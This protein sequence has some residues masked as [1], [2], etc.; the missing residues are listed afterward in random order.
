MPTRRLPSSPNLNHLKNQAKKLVREHQAGRV[1]AFTRIK[2]SFPPLTDA[3]VHEILAADFTLC[4]AQ[5][6]VSREYGFKTWKDLKEAIAEPSTLNLLLAE[7]PILRFVQDE[8]H[9]LSTADFPV[10]ISGEKGTGKSLAAQAIH[11]DSK[12]GSAPF[13]HVNCDSALLVDSEIFGHEEGAF[14]GARARRHGKVEAGA[15]GTLFLDEVGNLPVSV[16]AK[17]LGLLENGT[18]ER[19][20]GDEIIE[21]SVR[22]IASTTRD[23]QE[24]VAGGAFR[25]DLSL[26]LGRLHLKLL[27]LRK[28][29]QDIP[30]LVTHFAEQMAVHMG[31]GVPQLSAGAEEAL[32]NYEWPGN[33]RELQSIVQRAIANC[34]GSLIQRDDLG[35]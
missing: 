32:R 15:G 19:H 7:S 28:R 27:P 12:R 5:L 29:E 34:R 6:V 9:R 10:L 24:L 3:S 14:T 23:L 16:Q 4:N 20:G 31:I 26:L 18:F 21:S 30:Q 1:E 35:L 25:E 2:A 33:V 11:R 8:L 17:V 13:L 22:L